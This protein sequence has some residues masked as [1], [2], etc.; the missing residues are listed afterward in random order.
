MLRK[1]TRTKTKY[2]D[3][4]PSYDVSCVEVEFLSCPLKLVRILNIWRVYTKDTSQ[5]NLYQQMNH[6][7]CKFKTWPVVMTW[8]MLFVLLLGNIYIIQLSFFPKIHTHVNLILYM[9]RPKTVNLIGT[10]NSVQVYD[11]D[12]TSEI[13]KWIKLSR[14]TE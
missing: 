10:C 7:R 3:L 2:R 13:N 4:F 5:C 1:I 6:L 9:S 14:W 8:C 12:D 11:N